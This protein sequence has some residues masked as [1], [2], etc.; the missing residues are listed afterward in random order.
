VS[1]QGRLSIGDGKALA[2]AANDAV[3][4]GV[5]DRET[6]TMLGFDEPVRTQKVLT[7]HGIVTRKI[8]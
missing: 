3:R 2:V 6:V 7:P 1:C 4:A 5:L 8:V